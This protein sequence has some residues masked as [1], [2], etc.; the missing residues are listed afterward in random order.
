MNNVLTDAEA[1]QNI[2]ANVRRLRGDRSLSWLAKE[3]GTSPIQISRIE[4]GINLP[5]AGI[6]ARLA[7]TLAVSTDDLLSAEK[8]LA[9]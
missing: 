6:L 7:E 3:I 4:A 9:E 2:A 5:G 1:R 8:I